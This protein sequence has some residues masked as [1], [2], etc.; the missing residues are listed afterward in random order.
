ML[1]ERALNLQGLPKIKGPKNGAFLASHAS[2]ASER[3]ERIERA[4]RAL[5]ASEASE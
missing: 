4:M 2:V 5:L 1:A 3:S